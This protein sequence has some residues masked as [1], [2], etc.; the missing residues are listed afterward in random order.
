VNRVHPR[1]CDRAAQ[2]CRPEQP[3]RGTSP[4]P[5]CRAAFACRACGPGV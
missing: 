1:R 4:L 3:H 5:A 2:D